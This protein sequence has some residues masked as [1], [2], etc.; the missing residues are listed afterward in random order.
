MRAKEIRRI[1]S[2]VAA[3]PRQITPFSS[4][5]LRMH[6]RGQITADKVGKLASSALHI[7][8]GDHAILASAS[9]KQLKDGCSAKDKRRAVANC[10]RNLGRGIRKI[11]AFP[12]TLK[13]YKAFLPMWNPDTNVPKE[14]LCSILLPH[15][16]LTNKQN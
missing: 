11:A 4:D 7:G 12:G 5:V 14:R 15:E 2:D 13:P 10:S 9:G 6:A 16:V 8:G 3:V 1:C